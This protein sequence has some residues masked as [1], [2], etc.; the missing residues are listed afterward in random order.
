MHRMP[1]RAAS[2]AY[3]NL[4]LVMVDLGGWFVSFVCVDGHFGG[5]LMTLAK[6]D[7]QRRRKMASPLTLNLGLEWIESTLIKQQDAVLEGTGLDY[8]DSKSEWVV[9]G[10][11]T[12]TFHHG[13]TG[14]LDSLP[15]IF[16]T[17]RWVPLCPRTHR[18]C[19][20]N[21]GDGRTCHPQ[22]ACLHHLRTTS[23]FV[24]RFSPLFLSIRHRN[25]ISRSLLILTSWILLM[26]NSI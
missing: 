16:Y 20:Q 23:K 24:A 8:N 9:E 17:V 7:K 12:S 26:T 1:F 14:G 6:K 3:N 21:P 4:L 11:S 18:V 19:R 10:S 22:R 2:R 5:C 13:Q 15:R 25:S